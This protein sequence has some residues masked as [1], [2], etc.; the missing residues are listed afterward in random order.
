MRRPFQNGLALTWILAESVLVLGGC[1]PKPLPSASDGAHRSHENRSLETQIA[2]VQAGRSD[3]IHAVDRI[4]G[5]ADWQAIGRLHAL[6]VLVV[7]QGRAEDHHLTMLAEL[8]GLERLVLRGSPVGDDGLRAIAGCSTL[9]DLNIPQS[10]CTA[11][12]VASLAGL[13]HLHALRIGSRELDGLAC[14]RALATFPSLRSIHLIDVAIGDDGL[15]ILAGLEGL[16]NLYLD[17]AGVSDTAWERYC[18][19]RPA[20]HVHVDQRHHDR[21]PAR[22]GH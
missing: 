20:V 10:I 21:D 13:P 9:H 8:P 1:R 22:H 14:S 12:G 18:Q 17:G 5:E 7:E 15:D 4:L 6:R 19:V 3:A 11:E 2:A 16:E